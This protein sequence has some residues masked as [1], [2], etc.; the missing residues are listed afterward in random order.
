MPA[1]FGWVIVGVFGLLLA[2]AVVFILGFVLSMLVSMVHGSIL[3][4]EHVAERALHHDAGHHAG[5]LAMH[6]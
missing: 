1:A 4:V 3:G 2:A 5:R 6:H